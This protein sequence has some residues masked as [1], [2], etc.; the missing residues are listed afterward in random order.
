MKFK[1]IFLFELFY[2]KSRSV[3]YV[4][5][6]ITFLLC[7]LGVASSIIKLGGA[8]GMIKANAPYVIYRMTLVSSF[9]LTIITSAIM[10]VA[11]V[12]DFDHNM[13]GILFS[14]PIRK[15]DYLLG[16]FLGSF[17]TLLLINIA[18]PL[19]FISGFL[20]GK[21]VPWEVAWKNQELF[22][23]HLWNYLHP[24]FLILIPNLFVTCS[25]FFMGGALGRKSIVIY[26]QGILLVVLY[27]IGN[28]YLRDLDSQ[29]LAGIIDPFGI[30]TFLYMT[31]YWT[32][33]EQN[34]LFIPLEGI[35]LYNRLLWLVVGILALFI[36][37]HFFSFR[38][39]RDTSTSKKSKP[40]IA[41][42]PELEVRLMPKIHVTPSNVY[43][44]Q[45]R[46]WSFLYFK[47]VWKEIPFLAI[48]ASGILLL[49]LNVSRISSI[50]GTSA[51]PTT[52][53]ILDIIN[54]SFNLFFLIIV[55]FYSGELIWKERSVNFHLI[56]DSL[57]VSS[58]VC[59]LSKFFALLLIYIVLILLLI[60]CG[61]LAQTVYGYYQF[62]LPVYFETLFGSTFVGLF[63]F[64]LL[65]FFIQ[66]MVNDKFAGFVISIVFLVINALLPQIGLEHDLWQFGSGSLGPFSEINLYGH[67][68]T[69]FVWFKTYWMA[70][71]FILLAIAALFSARGAETQMKLRWKAGKYLFTR[72][73]F[74]FFITA[75]CIFLF[76]GFYIYYNTT[77][78]NEFE[79]ANTHTKKQADYE[80]LL[81]RYNHFVQ[82]KIVESNI[83]IDLF[84]SRRDFIAEGYYYLKNKSPQSIQD[85]HIQYPMDH[86]LNVD[87]LKF[88]GEAKIKEGHPI[89]RY[90]IYTLCNPL[91][92]GDSVK[93]SFKLSFLTKGFVEGG[94]N[95]DIVYN[96]TFFN[97]TYFPS[98]GYNHHFELK[99]LAD[100]KKNGL[101]EIDQLPDYYNPE[102][103]TVNAFGDDADRIR[104]EMIVSTEGDQTAIA[105]GYLQHEW[106]KNNRNYF[107]YKTN[108]PISNYYSIVSGRY[109]VRRDQWKDVS[110]EIYYH[111]GHEF[112]L[113][114]MM[115]GMKDALRYC[116]DNFSP[117]QFRQLR[118]LEF[119]RYQTFAP[120]YAYT[121]PYSEN[122]SFIL[123]AKHPNEDLDIAYY[124][125]AH[126]VA[127]QW[128]GQQ[129]MEAD[130][131][132]GAMLSEGMSQYTALMVM[133]HTFPSE[134]VERYLK[135]ELDNYLKGRAQSRTREY[136][137]L[138]A[139][140]QSY[141]S[142]N[143]SSLIFYALQDY[144]G[145]D[146]LNHAFKAYN[147]LW[148]F[149]D[150]PYPSSVDL[151]KQIHQVTPDSL[152]YLLHDMFETVT[153]FENQ[154][155]VAAYKESKKGWF[156][157]TLS[158]SCEKIRIDSSG[159]EKTIPLHDWIDVGVYATDSNG[160]EKLI[161]LKK[162]KVTKKNNLFVISIR[163]PPSRAGIDPL[164]K[165]ID[166]HSDDNTIH[167]GQFLELTNLPIE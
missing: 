126:E 64:T 160:K 161:Y 56:I 111:R 130:A 109:A 17:V 127:H 61:I 33:A 146:N 6:G 10:G 55:I 139:S 23:F 167:V 98:L 27:Q 71:S 96:G 39:V 81:N 149:N 141:V 165:L 29:Y 42:S 16:R 107:H 59:L 92:P 136:P 132:G 150:S 15:R 114:K 105:P 28:S 9:V 138:S 41:A 35:M 5:F 142:Y 129:V 80:K 102:G 34:A 86:P 43:W 38:A 122:I 20:V 97:N 137:L 84:P 21:F 147:K 45:I 74:L 104:F 90:Y 135:Y 110:L 116:A 40:A 50:Y 4:Y 73:L 1:E 58:L 83:S 66:V 22:L 164:H 77:I 51:Y 101:K 69:P 152:R 156:E 106:K 53:S 3:T 153:L 85:I 47:M 7:F 13:E 32:P 120:S 108:G 91:Q 72:S 11:I 125:T 148:A 157:L 89:F 49:L 68:I 134:V 57:P 30:Q 31:R 95:T 121:I 103:K 143:K 159:R 162:H 26:M 60:T 25:L 117:F 140:N 24:F 158:V 133:K 75:S 48:V 112:N 155:V 2:R 44:N 8:V 88:E 70:F 131:K 124:V 62:E 163:E 67:F 94:S 18:I 36:T 82:P 118:I 93:M 52:A 78:T 100:R 37:Y 54:N 115:K 145:E 46:D 14:A 166:R 12:R 63:L 123:K 113:D 128:W 154:S 79:G 151:L 76:S 65:S 19:G 119:P 99:D 144:L 87:Y